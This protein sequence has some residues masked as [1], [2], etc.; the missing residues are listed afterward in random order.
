M[1]TTEAASA[2]RE[3]H[4]WV[5]LALPVCLAGLFAVF[6]NKLYLQPEQALEPLVQERL[7]AKGSSLWVSFV[8]CWLGVVLTW[9]LASAK[10]RS[11][12]RRGDIATFDRAQVLFLF[13][14]G[15]W[16]NAAEMSSGYL[17]LAAPGIEFVVL[18]TFAFANLGA[19]RSILVSTWTLIIYVTTSLP[20]VTQ[21][22]PW[23][24]PYTA[25]ERLSSWV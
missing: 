23:G 5:L 20:W 13:A 17:G 1:T 9:A 12:N 8:C 15:Q 10:M 2:E 18:F 14:S 25:R 21:H 11:A 16:I 24:H 22:S 19:R 3:R 7:R 4:C 6:L